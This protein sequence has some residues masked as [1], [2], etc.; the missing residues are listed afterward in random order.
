M[1]AFRVAATCE[2]ASISA[3]FQAAKQWAHHAELRHESAIEAYHIAINLLPR[4]AMLSLDVHSRQQALTCSDGLAC[5]AAA[6]A[7]QSGQYDKAVELLEEGRGIFWSQALKLRT[8]MTDLH[9]VAPQLEEKLG[10]I[11]VA[12]E[13]GSLRDVSRNQCDTPQKVMSMEQEASHFHRL[14]DE[15]L[16]TVEEVRQLDSFHDF[17]RP[18]HLSQLLGAAAHGSVV[19][20]NAS[21][22]GCA[23][24]ILTSTSVRHVP[25]S[26]LTFAKVT[27]LVQLIRNATTQ[28]GRDTLLP[29]YARVECLLQQMPLLSDTVQSFRLALESRHM[30]RTPASTSDHIFR[31]TLGV[32]WESVVEPI[33]RMLCLKVNWIVR[34]NN[35][36]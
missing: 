9:D 33:I 20:L 17:L 24:L 18:S 1:P 15:W 32:L 31:Y 12:L 14:N 3:R 36:Y 4:L 5:D 13:R 11:S 28:E 23:A 21:K 7:I 27:A 22:A 26:Q 2:S 10:R 16:A 8:P 30:K 6:C 25:L 29:K 19:I 34:V 35:C